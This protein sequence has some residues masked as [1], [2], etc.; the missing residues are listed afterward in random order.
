M[1]A[2]QNTLASGASAARPGA[3]TTHLTHDLASTLRHF[4]DH[5]YA[6][7]PAVL[8]EPVLNQLRAELH[9]LREQFASFPTFAEKPVKAAPGVE[10]SCTG[11]V[12]LQ[13]LSLRP[14][15][16]EALLVAEPAALVRT[17]LGPDARLEIVGGV[18]TDHTRPFYPWHVHVGGPDDTYLRKAGVDVSDAARRPRRLT[19]LLYLDG[20]TAEDGPLHVLPTPAGQARAAAGGIYDAHW[21]G[22]TILSWPA[23]SVVLLDER[24]WHAAPQRTTPG[25]RRWV[26]IHIAAADV[27]LAAHHDQSLDGLGLSSL[28]AWHALGTAPR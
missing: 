10:V 24:T 23:G 5:G 2:G 20:V 26:G 13:L 11:M 14:A 8:P 18:V 4:L 17:L 16:A 21:P 12:F 1:T 25:P 15:L 22:E 27:P 19:Y 6:V 3:E 7:F 28:S 9:D